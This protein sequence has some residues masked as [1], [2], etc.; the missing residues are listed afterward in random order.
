ML[1]RAI[2][3]PTQMMG[4]DSDHK[5]TSLADAL[6]QAKNNMLKDE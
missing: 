2:G 6:I 4:E 5:F 3:T 1:N